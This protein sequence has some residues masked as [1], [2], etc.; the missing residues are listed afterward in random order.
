MCTPSVPA[1][2]SPQATATAQEQ[3]NTQ[4]AEQTAE[5]NAVNQNT[6]LGSLDY[7]ING[8]NAD[9]TPQYTQTETYAP[10]EQNLLNMYQTGEQNLGNTAL[11]M[12]GQVASSYAQPLNTAGIPAVNSTGGST[13]GVVNSVGSAGSPQAIQDAEN[14]AYGEQTQYLNPQFAQ[15]QEALTN[16]LANEGVTQGSQAANTAQQNLGLQENQAYGNAADQAVLAGEGEQNTLYGQGLQSA[17][18]ANTA[19]NQTYGEQLQN[20]ELQNSASGQG[21]S[22]LFALTDQ[23]L[24]E[25]DALMS[26]SQV[27]SPTFQGTNSE[28]VQPANVGSI[29]NGAYAN[30][31]SAYGT[32]Q[33]GV[34]N[35]FS[36]GGSLGG[37]A[38]LASDRRLKKNITRVGETSGGIPIY[39]FSYIWDG[40]EVK[41]VGVMA[42]EV[43]KTIPE[44]VIRDPSGFDLVNYALV[45]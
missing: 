38:I 14:A 6:P 2:P 13:S 11:N 28:T 33:S 7:S 45:K 26:G 37:A 24:N 42:D 35:L 29:I 25:Y 32:Q 1:A 36:L 31:L 21:M 22:Q 17:D 27:Q 43:K 30:Q 9:G 12:Q 15:S 4:S 16:N 44:A 34:N 8:Y 5:M 39:E 23:P 20:A 10:A 19:Q 3:V 18:L 41:Y 40:D